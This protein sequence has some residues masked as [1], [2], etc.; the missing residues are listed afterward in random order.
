MSTGSPTL[1]RL[2]ARLSLR[3]R[4]GLRQRIL[5]LG[6]IIMVPLVLLA[7]VNARH[8][9]DI[10]LDQARVRAQLLL[11]AENGNYDDVVQKSEIILQLL[12]RSPEIHDAAGCDRFLAA[13][14]SPYPWLSS[15]FVLD[16]RG[17]KLCSSVP[18]PAGINASDRDYFKQAMATRKLAIS[19]YL[20][21]KVSQKPVI[22]SALPVLNPAGEVEVVVA[23]AISLQSLNEMIAADNLRRGI[24]GN[25]STTI[26][27]GE[28]TIVARYP[29]PENCIG[30]K[31]A[32]QR[33]VQEILQR[34]TGHADLPGLMGDERLFAFQPF[35]G[36]PS[37]IAVGIAKQP[38]L[39]AI[40]RRLQRTLGV[41]IA[42]ILGSIGLGLLGSEFLIVR[43]GQQL[44]ELAQRIGQG[45]YDIGTL[46]AAM[47]ETRALQDSF[48]GMA[49]RLKERETALTASREQLRTANR[50][51]VLAEQVAHVGHWRFDLP[52]GQVSWSEEVYRIHGV[53]PA[54]FH[55]TRENS[56]DAYHPDD[57]PT[58][59]KLMDW[60]IG[61]TR[62]FEFA[63]RIVRP[64]GE[65]RHVQSRGF[66]ELDE[67][68]AVVSIFGVLADITI[69]KEAEIRLKAAQLA[70][71]AANEA[72][73]AFLSTVSHELRQPLTSI[74]GF[75][76]LLLDRTTEPE[77]Q[78]YLELQRGSGE[79]LLCLINDLLDHSKIEA[80]MVEIE[81]VPISVGEVMETCGAL[82]VETARRKRIDL[83]VE[84][85]PALPM[86]QGDSARLQQ[87]LL[88]LGGN[89]LKFTPQGTVS[90]RCRL[91]GADAHF[92]RLRFEV[93]DSGIGIPAD[94]LA[95]LFQRFRQADSSIT[96]RFGGTGLG[97]TISK[98]LV[99]SMHG[100]IGVES[101]EGTGTL[102]WFEI[103]FRLAASPVPAPAATQPQRAPGRTGE[104]PLRILLAEDSPINQALFSEI[105]GDMGHAVS[106]VENGNQALQ[107][108]EQEA[109]DLVL[110][111]VEMPELD[112]LAATR[113]LRE[114]GLTLPVIGLTGHAGAADAARCRAAGMTG[115]L[116]KPVDFAD[117]QAAVEQV[118]AEAAAGGSAADSVAEA[119]I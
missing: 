115:C 2:L 78:R 64:D 116:V 53:D 70:A 56:L 80:G 118:R 69:L 18:T 14:K 110:M 82:L 66:C 119:R 107:R 112:G 99:E 100:D 1:D 111:D 37:F 108:L 87:V 11:E 13:T 17:N 34:K 74:I 88:N 84:I 33:F 46:A 38:I 73:S 55:P 98:G 32:D 85:A 113:L 104:R 48:A 57:R 103:A 102:F 96:R 50:N 106:V 94:R 93:E 59:R 4:F 117:L 39:D 75:A 101:T 90:L 29:A 40:N 54:S 52:T 15:L 105:L 76:E 61:F 28:G 68:G 71:E 35:A 63:L 31:A 19:N 41:I 86:V 60:A 92:A 65:I 25:T 114:R 49:A 7:I 20:I 10:A 6:G 16:A 62:D 9:A 47:P 67:A 58:V 23:A 72:K 83:V 3:G 21:S 95:H 45:D 97:L 44:A 30:E 109:Y 43:P 79:H 42:T 89:A 22:T 12:S 77:M 24:D 51:L 81:Q 91:I 26:V 27:D 36:T 8:N 5:V